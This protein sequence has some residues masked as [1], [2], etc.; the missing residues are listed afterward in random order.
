MDERRYKCVE[1]FPSGNAS[2]RG[3]LH[4]MHAMLGKIAG[5]RGLK[6]HIHPGP[7]GENSY[8]TAYSGNDPIINVAA[9]V[10]LDLPPKSV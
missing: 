3:S 2:V 5:T 10:S 1:V 4:A 7:F 9:Y 6:L 8:S